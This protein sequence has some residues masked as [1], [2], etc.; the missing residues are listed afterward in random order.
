MVGGEAFQ[1]GELMD[2]TSDDVGCPG[3]KEKRVQ[4]RKGFKEVHAI[5][6]QS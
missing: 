3:E 1:P 6:N 2:W 5:V 4:G